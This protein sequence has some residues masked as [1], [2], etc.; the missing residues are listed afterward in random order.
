MP[1][2]QVSCPECQKKL[3]VP[4]DLSGKLVKCP[5]CGHT[6]TAT[7]SAPPPLPEDT[8]P[9]RTSPVTRR[10]D[11]EDDED[12]PRARRR[13]PRYDDEDE[14]EDDD[15]P[16]RSRRRY[17]QPHRGTLILV[18]GILALVTGIVGLILGPIAWVM[19]NTDMTE[20]RNGR[21]DPEGEGMTNAGR[22]CGMIA[23]LLHALWLL[24]C[25][26]IGALGGLR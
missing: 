23:T 9:T 7:L 25:C 17:T 12:K 5:T 14:D 15:Y 16:R 13:R 19:G 8:V 1:A 20:I 6:F 21:M 11:D 3:R 2:E 18:L 26:A 22:I 4:E 10:R 24:A